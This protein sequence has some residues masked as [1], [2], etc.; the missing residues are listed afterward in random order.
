LNEIYDER[1]PA[2]WDTFYR[3]TRELCEAYPDVPYLDYSHDSRFTHDF[4]LFTDG[5]HLNASGAKKFTAVVIADLHS[6]L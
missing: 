6:R 3:F 2:F 5:D 4:S 1:L